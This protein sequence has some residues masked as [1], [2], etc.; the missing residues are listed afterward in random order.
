[1]VRAAV[2]VYLEADLEENTTEF[3][4]HIPVI[5]RTSPTL[6]PFP[7]FITLEIYGRRHSTLR[8][9]CRDIISPAVHAHNAVLN[10]SR[11]SQHQIPVL[12][13]C[14]SSSF[15]YTRKVVIMARL[16]LTNPFKSANG[17]LSRPEQARTRAHRAAFPPEEDIEAQ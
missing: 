7:S 6:S 10:S 17:G 5:N 2:F 9:N 13:P 1:M 16:P 14:L 12:T 8:A 4:A 3:E 11:R 15:D